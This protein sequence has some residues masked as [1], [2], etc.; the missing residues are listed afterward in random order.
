MH[1]L[2]LKGIFHLAENALFMS[3]MPNNPTDKMHA[4][5]ECES[6]LMPAFSVIGLPY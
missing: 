3:N 5:A 4:G 2:Q 6:P 1:D